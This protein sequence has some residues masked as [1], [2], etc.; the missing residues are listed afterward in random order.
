MECTV[1]ALGER[2]FDPGAT[3]DGASLKNHCG[4]REKKLKSRVTA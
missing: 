1:Q 3:F 4:F 2:H